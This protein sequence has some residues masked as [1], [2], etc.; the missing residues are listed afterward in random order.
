MPGSALTPHASGSWTPRRRP[1]SGGGSAGFRPRCRPGF[2]CRRDARPF[3]TTARKLCRTVADW[4]R[5]Y[6]IVGTGRTAQMPSG[7]AR[8]RSA[9]TVLVDEALRRDLC[10]DAVSAIYALESRPAVVECD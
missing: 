10:A 6:A 5:Y 3:R 2:P 9:G 8:R 1:P 7:L 4:V